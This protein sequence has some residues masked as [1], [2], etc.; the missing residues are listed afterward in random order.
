MLYRGG[1]GKYL[2]TTEYN[3]NFKTMQTYRNSFN[4]EAV[5]LSTRKLELEKSHNYILA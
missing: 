3:E 2:Q 4:V 1:G 5:L